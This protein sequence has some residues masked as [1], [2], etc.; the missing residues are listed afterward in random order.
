[1]GSTT[2][3][4]A[5]RWGTQGVMLLA[6]LLALIVPLVPEPAAAAGPLYP[7][8]RPT[9]PSSLYFDR[10]TVNGSSQYILRFSNTVWNAGEGRLELQGD[11]NPNGSN[12]V[13][14]NVYNAASGGSRVSQTRVTS[15]LLYHPSHFHYHFSNFASYLLLKRDA[16]GTYQPTTAEGTKTSFCILD[17]VRFNSNGPSAPRYT[18]CGGTLQGLSVGWSD[19]YVASLPEQW[20][21]LG[22]SPLAD[23]NYAIQTTV[24]PLNL[25]NEGGRDGNN[26]AATYFHVRNGVII[27]GTSTSEPP[28]GL[29]G[30]VVNTGG[31]GLYCRATPNGTI[32]GSSPA[33]STVQVT[34]A[35]QS[36][37]VPIICGG[38]AG[39]SSAAYLQISGSAATTPTPTATA[40]AT[41]TA[42]TTPSGV[43]G[44]VQNTGGANLNCRST[45]NGT[46]IAK[47]PAGTTVPVR[48]A[49]QSGWVPV[50]CGGQA[51]WVSADY[52]R[53]DDGTT[54]EPPEN[55]TA[56]VVN[57]GGLGV[58]CRVTAVNGA[59]ITVLPEGR[60]VEVTGAT[61]NGWVP[62]VCG[63]RSG[64]VSG[65]YLRIN[66]R[67]TPTVTPTPTPTPTATPTVTPTSGVTETPVTI[68]P[69]ATTVIPTATTVPPSPTPTVVP[70]T[71]T[72]V[73]TEVPPTPVPTEVPP[74]VVPTE[75]PGT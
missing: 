6:L 20:V 64:W 15:D 27:L 38:R 16:N 8:L 74:V 53:I 37:W 75:E 52:L 35:A 4:S 57:T 54:T 47:L 3:R 1:M 21:V 69:T 2:S 24:D 71:P 34:G 67:P 72:L 25:L 13:Y 39:W 41:P 40:S 43:I 55:Q 60:T 5:P 48:G 62:V 66:P 32:I 42:S 63:D 22:S 36:G 19:T 9:A 18:S 30:R 56:T 23:G 65:A 58:R 59:I 28:S 51:G 73:P 7:D 26:T 46:I 11:P 10:T 49:T 29:V 50:T 61:R 31:A 44:V 70:P 12:A 68:E 14:Q 33:N 17:Y 45:P